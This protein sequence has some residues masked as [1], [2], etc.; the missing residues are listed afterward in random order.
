VESVLNE[1]SQSWTELYTDDGLRK[2]NEH[3][4]YTPIRSMAPF[5]CFTCRHKR[6][7]TR[8]QVAPSAGFR[9]VGRCLINARPGRWPLL[10][11]RL[12]PC[13]C[14]S[15]T[16]VFDCSVGT[17]SEK[18]SRWTR[19]N[20]FPEHGALCGPSAEQ[21]GRKSSGIGARVLQKWDANANCP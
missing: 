10:S 5:N 11:K 4:A 1:E 21:H 15:I 6:A 13:W 8:T 3:P 14:S 20:C 18:T 16:V 19:R 2:G 9:N 7:K 12:Y 17:G